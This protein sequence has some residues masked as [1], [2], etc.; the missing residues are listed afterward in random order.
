MLMLM[1]R[2]IFFLHFSIL[3][4]TKFQKNRK[5]VHKTRVYHRKHLKN[6]VLLLS[7]SKVGPIIKIDQ[8]NNKKY[9]KDW[10]SQN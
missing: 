7:Q 8:N 6:I 9:K 3:V 2:R 4:V 1:L 5:R 10:E